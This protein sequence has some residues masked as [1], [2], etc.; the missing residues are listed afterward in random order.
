MCIVYLITPENLFSFNMKT[1]SRKYLPKISTVITQRKTKP[2][3]LYCWMNLKK[4]KKVKWKAGFSYLFIF[5]TVQ[6]NI[7]FSNGPDYN[8]KWIDIE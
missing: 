8:G 4:K 5:F 6:R 3:T 2:Y 1:I 7:L